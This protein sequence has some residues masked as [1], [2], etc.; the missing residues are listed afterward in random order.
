MSSLKR[1]IKKMGLIF[2]KHSPQIMVVA[3]CAGAVTAAVMAC[4]ET[5]RL[6]ETLD[7]SKALIDDIKQLYAANDEEAY[8][9][10]D[11]KKDLTKCYISA[12]GK[13]V[14]LYAPSVALGIGSISL[15]FAS[16]NVMKKRNASL[17]AA[18]A[19]LDSMYR[20]YRKNVK[21]TFG[22][23]I[24]RDMRL[25]ITREVVEVEKVDEKTGKTKTVKETKEVV[26]IQADGRSD[27]ARFFDAGCRGWDPNPE[28]SLMFLKQVEQ[29][30]TRKLE[31]NGYLFLNDVYDE[32]GIPRTIAGQSVG[33]IY[34]EENPIG[35]NY[36]DFGI[37][38][39]GFKENREFVNGYED[40]ILLDFN[41]DGDIVNNPALKMWRK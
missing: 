7:D 25:G 5:L 14:K 40:V 11:Y 2:K 37:Y 31:S 6:E 4:K 33:W 17:G 34:D 19:T 15:I 24:D 18:Y 9:E 39:K 30:L 3:G 23:D 13:V 38:E 22:E 27:Y 36:V 20:S 8:P 41:V 16:N 28:Y 1:N 29:F 21:E 26:H 35:D 10:K 12:A 32:L